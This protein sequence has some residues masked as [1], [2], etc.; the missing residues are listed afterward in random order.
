MY[1][2]PVLLKESIDALNITPDGIYV[3][4]TFGGG[5]HSRAILKKLKNGR[6]FAFD[7]DEDAMSNRIDD[8]RITMINS[9]FRYIKNFLR[10]YKSVP[11]DGIIA[12]LGISS[13]QIDVDERGFSTRSDGTLDMRMDRRQELTAGDII[14]TYPQDQIQRVIKEFG[15]VRNALQVSRIIVSARK[16][17]LFRTTADLKETLESVAEKGK[18]NKYFAQVFQALRIEVNRE[19]ESLTELLINGTSILRQGG[20]FV[21]LSYHSL[22]D[23]II[24]DFFRSGN[25]AGIINKDFYGKPLLPL[26]V[27]TRK[28]IMPS[29]DEIMKN[30]RARSA[31][32]RI[33]E[34]IQ[35]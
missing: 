18:E 23:R 22:E 20:R 35:S 32:M 19:L 15:E 34:K 14:N 28:P 8:P 4:A 9:N 26:K 7:Q 1:H 17:K 24:K 16:E 30:K 33:A 10:F 25:A 3:D 11:V 21:I 31:R 13:H 29:D 2:N 5:G 6:L 12:D 27:I